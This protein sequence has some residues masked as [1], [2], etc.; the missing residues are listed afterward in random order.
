MPANRFQRRSPSRMTSSAPRDRTGSRSPRSVTVA[1][2]TTANWTAA[3]S[4]DSC[5]GFGA[6]DFDH[7]GEVGP[8][9]TQPTTFNTEEA[10]S[11][12]PKHGTWAVPWSRRCGDDGSPGGVEG[13]LK[14]GDNHGKPHCSARLCYNHSAT[15][16][17]G[18]RASGGH[19]GLPVVDARHRLVPTVW[20][21]LR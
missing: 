7:A 6:D 13:A 16:K 21:D 14:S 19:T 11:V 5:G 10:P 3:C 18:V 15:P 8:R 17:R 20:T 1:L 2:N 12:G 9:W 4:R